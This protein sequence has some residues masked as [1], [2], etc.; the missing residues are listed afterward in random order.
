MTL[1]DAPRAG[2]A[3]RSSAST[4]TAPLIQ[5]SSAD[6]VDKLVRRASRQA[7]IYSSLGRLSNDF[8]G[9]LR[10]QGAVDPMYR[11]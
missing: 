9:Y 11:S 1:P 2:W 7:G 10:R 3:A 5:N 8:S 6:E 4:I